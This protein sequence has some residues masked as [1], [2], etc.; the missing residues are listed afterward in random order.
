MQELI[1]PNDVCFFDRQWHSFA[2]RGNISHVLEKITGIHSEV[3]YNH[4]P[5]VPI[6][7]Y[8]VA[9]R[10]FW[11]SKRRTTR[12]EDEAYS[13]LGLFNVNIPLLYGE[14]ARS[15]ERL[16]QEIIRTSTDQSILA[17]EYPEGAVHVAGSYVRSPLAPSLRYF[18]GKAQR[19]IAKPSSYSNKFRLTN[20]GIEMTTGLEAYHVK[21][22]FRTVIAVLNCAILPQ[23]DTVGVW[24]RVDPEN[25][26]VLRNKVSTK[27]FRA[28]FTHK[29]EALLGQDWLNLRATSSYTTTV[30]ITRC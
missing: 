21:H 17:W 22:G 6:K 26:A 10:M 18:G 25:V 14:G 5:R 3:L 12:K 28:G 8:S 27:R 19:I 24:I 13:L 16:Q 20:E 1:A 23:M 9:Q 2:R 15:F 11:A 30:L 4:D 29:T 7:F